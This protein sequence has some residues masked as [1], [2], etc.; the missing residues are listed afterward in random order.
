MSLEEA[1]GGD[2]GAVMNLNQTQ[3]HLN[4]ANNTVSMQHVSA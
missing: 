1:A 2:A 3:M 4:S